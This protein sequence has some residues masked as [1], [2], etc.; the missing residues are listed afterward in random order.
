MESIPHPLRRRIVVGV[1]TH[2]YAHVAVALDQ[3]GAVIAETTIP[4]DRAG[5]AQLQ[6][7]ACE[8]GEQVEFGVEGSGSYGAGLVSFLRR[9]GHLVLEVNRPDRGV[10]HLRG[11]ND[12]ID[13]ESAARAVLSGAATAVPKTADGTVEMIR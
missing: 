13:A 7:W 3:V 10:R 5:Y 9:R 1:D 6:R 4:V 8:L 12:S 2:K 11:K